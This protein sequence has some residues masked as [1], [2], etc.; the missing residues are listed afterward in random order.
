[1]L[2]RF[3]RVIPGFM[4]QAQSRCQVWDFSKISNG[5]LQMLQL[6][7]GR[8]WCFELARPEVGHKLLCHLSTLI[9]VASEH[10]ADLLVIITETKSY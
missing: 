8:L 6:S 1:M 3:H 4:A 5:L 10:E 9:Q 2:L 7:H